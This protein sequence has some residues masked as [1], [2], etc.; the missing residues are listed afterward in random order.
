MSDSEFIVDKEN[1]EVRLSRIYKATPERLF[2][3]YTDPEQIPKWWGPAKYK[4]TVD[5]MDV[6]V[7][8]TWRFIHTGEDGTEY[9]FN[10]EYQEIDPPRK[11]VSTFEFEPVAGHILIETAT[12]E[13]QPDGTTKLSTVSKYANLEDL[14]G[15]VNSGMESGAVES[16]E[17][18]AALVEN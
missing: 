11:V 13:A 1:L 14:E 3:A 4:T 10:G 15:M 7:G 5:K 12:F 18:L 8:G 17:R 9:A 6:R 2:E 16:Q